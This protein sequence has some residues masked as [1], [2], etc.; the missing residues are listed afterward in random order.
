[1]NICKYE[2]CIKCTYYKGIGNC[3]CI[4][5]ISF[6]FVCKATGRGLSHSQSHLLSYLLSHLHFHTYM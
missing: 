5:F 4:I 6:G 2:T 3:K 1:M